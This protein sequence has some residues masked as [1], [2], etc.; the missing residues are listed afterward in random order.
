MHTPGRKSSLAQLLNEDEMEMLSHH[1]TLAPNPPLIA[2]PASCIRTI[3]CIA[4]LQDARAMSLV[5]RLLLYVL[6]V[7]STVGFAEPRVYAVL[8]L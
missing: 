7:L 5:A 6:C 8:P 1:R 2:R 4:T 3:A